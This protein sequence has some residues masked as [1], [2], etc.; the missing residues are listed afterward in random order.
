MIQE[1]NHETISS[2]D[3]YKRIVAKLKPGQNVVFKILRRGDNEH[4]LTIF[5]PG[6]VPA[7]NK[8]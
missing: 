3:D 7:D 5:L 1:I 2:L 6:V 4:T 8:N